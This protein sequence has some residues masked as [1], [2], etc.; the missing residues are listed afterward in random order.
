MASVTPRPGLAIV[1][2]NYGAAH[3]VEPNLLRAAP[4]ATTVVVVDNLA[5]AAD[6]AAVRVAADRHGWELVLSPGNVGFGAAVNAGVARATAL[7]S[8]RFL[9]LNPD[10]TADPEVVAALA[11]H[12]D[13]HRMSLV[14]PRIERPGRAKAWFVGNVVDP[15]SGDV[16]RDPSL[17]AADDTWGWLT[18][19]CLAFHEQVWNAAGG[20]DER[21]FLYW[22]D[23]DLSRRVVEAGGTLTVRSDLVA[24]HD[25]GGTQSEEA[26]AGT[27]KSPV[28]VYRNCCNRLRFA[29]YHLGR[30]ERLGWLLRT[31]VASAKIALRSGPRVALRS[32]ATMWA[33][34]R[35]SLVGATIALTAPTPGGAQRRSKR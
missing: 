7:G 19:A 31:P 11:D 8:S 29:A 10:A 23:I 3:L 26:P 4:A 28:Y 32:P 14:S 15:R 22:E 1:V 13:E 6:R 12:V 17:G 2:V 25:V 5:S 9:V 16:R 34:I 35:G 33:A 30:R 24:W 27:G 20:F 21:Y 18:G